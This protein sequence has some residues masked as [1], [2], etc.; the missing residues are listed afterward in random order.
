MLSAAVLAKDAA[1]ERLHE[2]KAVALAQQQVH[3]IFHPFGEENGAGRCG[4]WAERRLDYCLELV[5]WIEP[6][7]N[8]VYRRSL[9]RSASERYLQIAG[10]DQTP[11]RA[12][13]RSPAQCS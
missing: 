10:S 1:I 5:L 4:L 6:D 8:T 12:Q 3:G 11:I 9:V 7:P 13:A 2:E